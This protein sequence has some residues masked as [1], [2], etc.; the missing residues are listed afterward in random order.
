VLAPRRGHRDSDRR[1]HGT[2]RAPAG[3]QA[4][5]EDRVADPRPYRRLI[6]RLADEGTGVDTAYDF[7]GGELLLDGQRL[8][9]ATF[10][11]T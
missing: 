10:V 7:I 2:Q 9:M 6:D 3:P 4:Q 11:T 1:L 8:N 5:P